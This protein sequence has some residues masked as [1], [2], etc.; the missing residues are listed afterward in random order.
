MNN[1][2]DLVASLLE[3][4]YLVSDNCNKLSNFLCSKESERALAMDYG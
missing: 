4:A 2:D 1:D 3:G